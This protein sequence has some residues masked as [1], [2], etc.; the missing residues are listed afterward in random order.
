[1]RPVKVV[2]DDG[3]KTTCE[4]DATHRRTLAEAKTIAEQIAHYDRDTDMGKL[5][6][7]VSAGIGAILKG[8]PVETA[9]N[10]PDAK[11]KGADAKA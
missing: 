4:L 6:K 7:V 2:T 1:M 9:P 5:A 8:P 3:G 10:A 11:D